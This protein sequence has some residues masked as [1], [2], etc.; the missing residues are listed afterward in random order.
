M[1]TSNQCLDPR[2]VESACSSAIAV[3]S[4]VPCRAS[5]RAAAAAR[6]IPAAGAW[7]KVANDILVT[8]PQTWD[9]PSAFS[10]RRLLWGAGCCARIPGQPASRPS[11]PAY[12]KPGGQSRFLA[13][14]ADC[15]RL[16]DWATPTPFFEQGV[17]TAR[18]TSRSDLLAKG[19]VAG[20][21]RGHGVGLGSHVGTVGRLRR[22]CGL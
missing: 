15:K 16:Q 7:L 5:S 11:Y 2:V 18:R 14:Q 6:P 1:S 21:Q 3:R 20:T 4:T 9:R 12:A 13:L 19:R 10:N 22:C 8:L 17:A